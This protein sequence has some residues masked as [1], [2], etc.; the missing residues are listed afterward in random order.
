MWS[1]NPISNPECWNRAGSASS[2]QTFCCAVSHPATAL[3]IF[4]LGP[5]R[6]VSPAQVKYRANHNPIVVC[7]FFFSLPFLSLCSALSSSYLGNVFVLF[8]S[9]SSIYLLQY[10]F[11]FFPLIFFQLHFIQIHLLWSAATY[12]WYSSG[13]SWVPYLTIVPCSFA[14]IGSSLTFSTRSYTIL[15]SLSIMYSFL[16]H[17][18]W[19]SLFVSMFFSR[20]TFDAIWTLLVD[21]AIY[22]KAPDIRV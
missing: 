8:T 12:L 2:Y 3:E 16:F 1:I 14:S 7:W 5:L 21:C 19:C 11:P 13:H 18:S 6:V 22:W 20:T 10:I 4:L 17:L 15:L 9:A